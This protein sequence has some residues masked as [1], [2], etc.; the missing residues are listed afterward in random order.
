MRR[1][2]YD[3]KKAQERAY[4][5]L[6]SGHLATEEELE[7]LKA[8]FHLYNIQYINDIILAS[9]ELIYTVLRIAL[10]VYKKDSKD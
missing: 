2:Q 1:T 10:A 3:L 7:D 6:Q 4:S 9:L 5:I 8:L